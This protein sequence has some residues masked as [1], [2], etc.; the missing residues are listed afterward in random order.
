[1]QI[2]ISENIAH[3]WLKC[4]QRSERKAYARNPSLRVADILKSV[5]CSALVSHQD[6]CHSK[7]DNFLQ[8][9]AQPLPPASPA[10]LMEVNSKVASPRFLNTLLG[11]FRTLT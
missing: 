11:K 6:A 1:M 10:V 4:L 3:I 5:F 9:E 8:G 7:I 2:F